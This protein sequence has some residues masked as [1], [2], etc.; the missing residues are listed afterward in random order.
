MSNPSAAP[1]D[2]SPSRGASFADLAA[3]VALPRVTGLAP[4]ADGRRLAVAGQS[5]DPE[6]TKWHRPSRGYAVRLPDPAL[7]RG[8]GRASSAGAGAPEVRGRTPT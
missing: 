5:L 2:S 1:A 4:S 6:R 8:Y 7:S 3:V